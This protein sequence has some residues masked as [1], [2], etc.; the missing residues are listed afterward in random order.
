[1]FMANGKK[2]IQEESKQTAFLYRQFEQFGEL[3]L[4]LCVD[5]SWKKKI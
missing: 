2:K 5:L 3:F 4:T 1:M